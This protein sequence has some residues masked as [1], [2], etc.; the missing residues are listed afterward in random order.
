MAQVSK[1]SGKLDVARK[2]LLDLG[3]RNPLLNY[4]TLKARGLEVVD[5]NPME[6]YQTLVKDKKKMSFQEVGNLHLFSQEEHRKLENPT[7]EST[8]VTNSDS[9]STTTILDPETSLDVDL[10]NAEE[11]N[12]KLSTKLQTNYTEKQLEKRLLNTYYFARTYI[13]EQGVNILYMA[14]GMIHWYESSSSQELRKAPLILIPVQ[15]DRVSAKERFT[16]S[17]TE[18]E[19]G[20]NI[21]LVAKMKAEFG[22]DIPALSTEDEVEID[23]TSYFSEVLKAIEGQKNWLVDTKSIVV[24]FFSFG[25]FLMY[26]DLDPNI[27]PD[28]QRPEEHDIITALLEE[29]FR[30]EP[31]EIGEEDHIDQFVDLK[32][33]N[34]IMDADSSQILAIL[35]A[36]NGR[37]LVIQ[38]P[39]GT[40]KSQTI[41]NLIAEAI[42]HGK[43][44][45][46]VSEKMAALEVVKRR[47]DNVGLGVAC[48]ELH[49][50]KSNKKSLLNELASTLDLG[51]PTY[52]DEDIDILEDLRT[53]L[54]DYCDAVNLPVDETGV[55]PYNALGTLALYQLEFSEKDLRFPELKIEAMETW[56]AEAFRKKNAVVEELEQVVHSIGL[57]IEHPFWGSKKKVVLP[58]DIDKLVEKV[59]ES[60]NHLRTTEGKLQQYTSDLQYEAVNSLP[61]SKVFINSFQK[62]IDAP[63]LQGIS[64]ETSEWSN[65]GKHIVEVLEAVG[66]LTNLKE[67]YK[68]VL[69]PEAWKQDVLETRQH[70]IQYEDKWWKF[71]VKDYR[72]AKNR[73]KGF[74]HNP[75]EK[76]V[77]DVEL[78]DSIMEVRRLEDFINEKGATPKELFSDRWDTVHS[79][80]EEL[81]QTTKWLMQFHEDLSH[82]SISKWTVD[83]I[84]SGGDKSIV[85]EIKT[86]LD[87]VVRETEKSLDALEG[88][89]EFDS[90]QR[91]QTN[92]K[93]ADQAFKSL[94]D[95]LHTWETKASDLHEMSSYNNLLEVIKE[96][97]L[98]AVSK[99][100]ES[101][102]YAGERLVDCFEWNW[103]QRILMKA[104]K[105]RPS[106]SNF[107]VS[108]HEHA[109]KKF[110]ELDKIMVEIN[111][112]KLAEKHWNMLPHHE[113]GGQLGVLRREF[114]KKSRH[115]PIR[116]LIIRAG[117]AIQAIKPIFMMGPLSISTYIE[118]G[119]LEFDLVIFDEASQVKPVDAFGA[120]IRAKQ[121]VVVGDSKQ[122]PPTNFFDSITKEEEESDGEEHYVA[123]ME[124]ILGLFLGQNA[125]Q[126]MLKWHYRSR[127]ESLITV[128]N[129]EF[130]EDK[131]VTFPSPDG[132]RNASGLI[133]NYNPDT[134][135][136]R[137]R[138]RTNRDEAKKVAQAVMAH[139]KDHPNLT[140]GV[141]AFSMAQMQAILDELELLRRS[142]PSLES[143]F[144]AHEHEP[145]FVK[146]LENVQGDERDV[147]FISIGYGKTID[148]YLSM[149]FGALNREGGERRL[150]VLITRA[151][152]RCE[153][154]TNLKAE[155]IDLN[156]SNARGIKALKT[157]LKYAETGHLDVPT[158]TG[159]D[160]DSPFEEAVY[161][162]LVN[163]GYEVE[164]QVGSAGFFID[165]A[166][167]DPE[168]PGRYLLGI[169]CDGAAYHSARSA[170]DRDRLRQEVLEGLGWTIHR[171]WSTDWFRHQDRELKRVVEAI[172]K[173]K[174]YAK[175]N[176]VP[177]KK[178]KPT[179]KGVQEISRDETAEKAT[180]SV[181]PY[182]MADLDISLNGEE[183]HNI[184]ATI[185]AE[186][187]LEVVK[188]ESP[189]HVNE[190]MKRICHAVGIRRVGTRIQQRFEDVLND[191]E[192]VVRKDD[193][194]WARTMSVPPVR[195][196][197]G[198]IR[199]LE[200][201]CREEFEEAIAEAVSL[202]FGVHGDN[203][204]P[205]V[206][207]K[208][209]FSRVTEEMRKHLDEIVEGM[210]EKEILVDKGGEL[211]IK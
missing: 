7:M 141:A 53:R 194:I 157:F 48:L 177:V 62:V 186:W 196:R 28:H 106:L 42:G 184:P 15:L 200:L 193:F 18:D 99:L 71:L 150:N 178:T 139:A 31:S 19:I 34:H 110:Q 39:P 125:P 97:N 63:N 176:A 98:T 118:P 199:K 195:T 170:R 113:G 12:P 182:E 92:G 210:V 166:V 112:Y 69:L 64:F 82:A 65:K 75:K 174:I 95:L 73:V 175:A 2:E 54:N 198:A 188:V 37:N 140:L 45:L 138:S 6:V 105:E 87:S 149:G 127:H 25:K 120:I 151:R 17:F 173:A 72:S 192:E 41:T 104:F 59:E 147:I 121:A 100:A 126:R 93:L 56:S 155:D 129:H 168:S 167:V 152:L 204:A 181:V 16:M 123:D 119:S 159:K 207:A 185:L 172:E 80:W 33:A 43:K 44:V 130:Y 74:L 35:D 156:R 134:Y 208:L 160:F 211:I 90:N 55:S 70:L 76:Q 101:W 40:G 171:I 103:N 115:L 60:L 14:L 163:L 83:Y 107:E 22:I 68:E 128:S 29:G 50:H 154:F 27:W 169:E 202:S 117:N 8:T 189:I 81:L 131:L 148:G 135:Y 89:L 58:T 77:N 162:S 158:A 206:Y 190:L 114:E 209:G 4:R 102:E 5:K 24:G 164:A 116:Q 111:R 203:V 145:F 20:H 67:K 108:R 91:F 187:V 38:G 143:F 142:N 94:T 51:K 96:Q 26:R 179:N 10:D 180:S 57:P 49:S 61:E 13:E 30:E 144:S 32:N 201:I 205:L 88:W 146:N 183:I 85:Q 136:D 165:L 124:S 133:Y 132:D 66:A 11:G 23:I 46:F 79:D 86:D 84:K 9:E 3:L 47:L 122:M 109:V 21:S 1:I 161:R 137:G 191:C 52:K 78:V 36:N 197:T 153:V